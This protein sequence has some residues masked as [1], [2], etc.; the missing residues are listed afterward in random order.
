MTL[1]ELGD[2]EGLEYKRAKM[3]RAAR[4]AALDYTFSRY[5]YEEVIDECEQAQDYENLAL[6]CRKLL[7][8]S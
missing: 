2:R 7:V 5:D 3:L 1:E 8:R 6:L 4:V